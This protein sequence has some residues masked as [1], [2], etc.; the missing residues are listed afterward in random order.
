MRHVERVLELWDKV[1]G[2]EEL[3]GYALP[4]V[5][6]WA[7]ELGS[8][9]LEARVNIEEARRLYPSAVVLESLAIRVS[10]P[11]P[12]DV[13]QA[14]R[15]ANARFRAAADDPVAAAAAD[16]DFH[17]ALTERC[18]NPHLLAAL[19][20]V[21]QALLRYEGVYMRDPDRIAES[22]AQ[23]DSIIA[24]LESGDQTAAAQLVRANLS[25]GL[26]DLTDVIER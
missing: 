7:A 25:G 8:A 22:A 11:Y 21:K 26:P 6:E 19:R 13:L 9:E 5:V 12:S 18:D 20:P 1:P 14:L 17:R 10:P 15:D 16:D 24:A 2:A 23:H 3:A 4:S